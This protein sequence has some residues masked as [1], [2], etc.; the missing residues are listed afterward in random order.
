[1]TTLPIRWHKLYNQIQGKSHGINKCGTL[2]HCEYSVRVVHLFRLGLK[3][4]KTDY[5]VVVKLDA[6]VS[7][8]KDFCENI[9]RKFAKQPDLG[10]ASGYLMI[11]GVKEKKEYLPMGQLSFTEKNVYSKLEDYIYL[12]DGI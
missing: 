8:E 5:D 4:I 7:F 1:M 10:I 12:P 3:E 9:L 2:C 6:D 11:D